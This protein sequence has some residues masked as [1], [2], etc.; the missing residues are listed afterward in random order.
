MGR[1][2]SIGVGAYQCDFVFEKN[3][4]P[5]RLV[6]QYPDRIKFIS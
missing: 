2:G 1:K 3:G 5:L 6:D 4:T